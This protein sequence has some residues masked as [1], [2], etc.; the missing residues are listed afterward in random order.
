MLPKALEPLIVVSF[1]LAAGAMGCH[2]REPSSPREV[3]SSYAIALQAGRA[4]EAYDL[5]SDDAKKNMPFE[6]FA[7]MVKENPEEM[8]AISVAL[9]RPTETSTVT[10]TVTTP[11]GEA[12]LLRYEAGRWR[13][14]RSAIDVYAQ[15]T[16]EAALRSFVRAFRNKRYDVMLRFAPDAKREGLDETRLRTAFEGEQREEIERLTQ[17]IEAALP[18]AVIEHLG[19]RATMSYGSGGTVELVREHGVWKVEE[20]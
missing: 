17:A 19:E 2:P 4:K 16:P 10:A 9:V 18:T 7:R 8:R 5:L 14:D 13:V 1:A 3:L 15:D 6:A 12:L 20:F 11:D